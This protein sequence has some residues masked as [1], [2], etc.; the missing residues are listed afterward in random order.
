MCN[1]TLSIFKDHKDVK[2]KS[3]KP[4]DEEYL[5]IKYRG[6]KDLLDF[7]LEKVTAQEQ[8]DDKLTLTLHLRGKPDYH[9]TNSFLPSSLMFVI[10]YSSLFF[11]IAGFNERIMVSLTSLLVLVA[12]F[13]QA[14]DTYVK[15]PYYKL[16]DV[17]Y[18]WLIFLC[19]A[20]VIANALVNYLRV[21][22]VKS[23]TDLMKKV[24]AA[25]KCNIV[26]Q[27]FLCTCFMCLIFVF[28]LF[29]KDSV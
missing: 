25:K 11:P 15:T 29:G 13:S 19:F 21:L 16:I 18:V 9:I 27:I 3:Y 23:Q 26:C 10:C 22:K 24:L 5:E 4:M 2:W 8:G 7:D 12:L 6:D 28:V 20:V 17:W 1:L 14:T